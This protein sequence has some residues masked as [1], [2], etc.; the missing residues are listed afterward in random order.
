MFVTFLVLKLTSSKKNSGT[1]S[2]CQTVWIQI[3]TWSGFKQFANVS[4]DSAD[5]KSHHLQRKSYAMGCLH[6]TLAVGQAKLKIS[7]F[8]V[9]GLK[10]LGRVGTLF[11]LT[12]NITLCILKGISPFKMHKIIYFSENLTK[13]LGFT[14]KFR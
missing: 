1:L 5:N 2:E 14:C 6:M 9:T 7:V 8:Q 4:T 12:K 10:I 11:F 3:R 13:I